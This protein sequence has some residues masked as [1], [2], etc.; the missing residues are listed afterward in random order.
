MNKPIRAQIISWE[1]SDENGAF[2]IDMFG[3]TSEGK[4][5]QIRSSYRPP[6]YIKP[7]ADDGDRLD[8]SEMNEIIEQLEERVRSFRPYL[9]NITAE[10]TKKTDLCSF[11]NG[12]KDDFI[13]ISCETLEV[14]KKLC[15]S[16]VITISSGPEKRKI[17][18]LEYLPKNEYYFQHHEASQLLGR[19]NQLP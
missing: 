3:R 19:S 16:H 15:R 10:K 14:R 2:R 12:R 7:V 6:F 4:S 9:G 1:S 5:I 8:E 11:V 13:K 18:L 17:H